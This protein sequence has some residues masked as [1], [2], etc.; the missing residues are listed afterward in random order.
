MQKTTKSVA[1]SWRSTI[2]KKIQVCFVNFYF[3]S[4]QGIS[5]HFLKSDLKKKGQLKIG[6]TQEELCAGTA[7]F[8]GKHQWQSLFFNKVVTFKVACVVKI[9]LLFYGLILL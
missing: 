8:T 5:T 4:C 3:Q 9:K 2:T 7:K 6:T 1:A